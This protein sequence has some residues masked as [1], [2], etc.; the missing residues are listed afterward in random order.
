[1][2]K[3]FLLLGLLLAVAFVNAHDSWPD[4]E[5]WSEG[6]VD[7]DDSFYMSGSGMEEIVEDG[8]LDDNGE[9]DQDIDDEFEVDDHHDEYDEY[10]DDD[11]DYSDDDDA[12]L[13]FQ[14]HRRSRR[15]PKSKLFSSI[16]FPLKI[17]DCCIFK[18]TPLCN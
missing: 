5:D 3:V 7:D 12:G 6:S 18:V 16:L 1:M 8:D 11:D 2:N 15:S 9:D 14:G 17:A 10:D 13:E 4:D